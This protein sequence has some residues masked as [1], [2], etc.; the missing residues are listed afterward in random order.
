MEDQYNIGF[1]E[2]PSHPMVKTLLSLPGRGF[3]PWLGN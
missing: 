3:N 2:L 1:E